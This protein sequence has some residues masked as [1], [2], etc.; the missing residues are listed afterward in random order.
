MRSS[1][2]LVLTLALTAFA[3]PTSTV[4]DEAIA[5]DEVTAVTEVI[6]ID[7]SVAVDASIASDVFIQAC[8]DVTVYFARGTSESGTIGTSVGP[9]FQTALQN[10]L[11]GKSLEF[12]GVPYP[13]TVGGFLAGGDAGGA[14][15]MANYVTDK[16]NACPST[17]IVISGFSQGAQVT[18][19]AA[20]KLSAAIQNRVNAAVVFGDPKNG[21]PFAGVISSRSITFCHTGDYICTGGILITPQHSNYAQ[22]V[23]AAA[24]FVKARV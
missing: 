21:Q 10:A 11:G 8:A 23:G 9:H 15:T 19:L 2:A 12:V 13:A 3:A 17:K 14:T 22:D 5:V 20:G 1:F 16:A 7:E 24:A 6:A 4:P 18:H